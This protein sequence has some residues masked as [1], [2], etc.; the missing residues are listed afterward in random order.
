MREKLNLLQGIPLSQDPFHLDGIGPIPS[1]LK[2]S[3]SGQT[4][5]N[6]DNSNLHT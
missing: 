3:D 4:P 2:L 6:I 1:S 5:K